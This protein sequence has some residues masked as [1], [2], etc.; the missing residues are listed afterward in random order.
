MNSVIFRPTEGELLQAGSHCV[1]GYAVAGEAQGIERVE[2]SGDGGAVWATTTLH[3]QPR[4]WTWCFWQA[5]ISLEP[6]IHQLVVRAWDSAGGTQPAEV[7]QVWNWK[8]F[9]NNVWHR[10]KVVV[11]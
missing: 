11:Q 6:G 2:V 9:L 3:D 1:G 10:V 7:G 8:G 5:T 4:P